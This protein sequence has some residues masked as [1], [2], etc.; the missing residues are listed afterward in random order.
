MIGRY[1]N[2]SC[3]FVVLYVVFLAVAQVNL[4]YQMG[5][6]SD[7]NAAGL[8]YCLLTFSFQT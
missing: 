1:Q 8:M 4:L 5:Q 6:P 3:L 2:Q 7:S